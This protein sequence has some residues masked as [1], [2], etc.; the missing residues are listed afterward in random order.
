MWD[1][2]QASPAAALSLSLS[3][4]HAINQSHPSIDGLLAE[5]LSVTL[6]DQSSTT[7]LITTVFTCH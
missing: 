7:L 4:H 1:Q 3:V 6:P 5:L 2:S